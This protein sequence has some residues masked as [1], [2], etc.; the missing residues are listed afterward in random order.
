MASE[1]V[2]GRG[3]DGSGGQQ[4]SRVGTWCRETWQMDQP[5]KGPGVEESR[6]RMS[7]SGR[8]FRG[9]RGGRGGWPRGG[10]HLI[11][12]PRQETEDVAWGGCGGQDWGRGWG[13]RAA[14]AQGA[15]GPRERPSLSPAGVRRPRLGPQDFSG[16]M[17]DRA[18][19]CHRLH[20][21]P[22]QEIE[23]IR[24]SNTFRP[25]YCKITFQ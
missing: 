8:R 3:G 17:R 20:P 9:S 16:S 10:L 2:R 18:P 14:G 12:G 25:I 22:R 4:G 11:L 24:D 5:C 21:H 1:C 7:Q 15:G 13:L 19:R 23:F 6:Q